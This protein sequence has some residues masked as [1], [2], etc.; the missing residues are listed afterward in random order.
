MTVIFYILITICIIAMI[1]LI[2]KIAINIKFDGETYY[3][4][5]ARN[6][7]NNIHGEIFDDDAKLAIQYGEAIDNPRAI[8]HY[9][10][11]TVYLINA[12]D[13]KNAH[14]HFTHA[15]NHVI[16]GKVDRKEANF[17]IDR[18][19]DYEDLFIDLLDMDNLPIQEAILAHIHDMKLTLDNVHKKKKKIKIDKN[20]PE[21]TQKILLSRQ[22]WQSDSQNVHDSAIY[23]ELKE[24][25]SQIILENSDIAGNNNRKYT[26]IKKWLYDNFHYDKEKYEMIKKTLNIIDN[27]YNI[28]GIPNIKEQDL[29]VNIWRRAYDPKNISV[30]ESIKNAI[31]DNLIDCVEGGYVVCMSGRTSKIWSSLARLDYNP[32][33]GI[34]KTKQILRN[35]IYEKSA[36]IVDTH[37]NNISDENKNIYNNGDTNKEIDDMINLIYSDIDNLKEDYEKLLPNKQLD[38]VLEECKSVI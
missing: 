1:F 26:D 31:A 13:T 9:R 34:F 25:L 36:K 2:Y 21:F 32:D 10:L 38:L 14:N 8:D 18:I 28:S 30:M 5:L 24:Q 35:E 37:L 23:K 12:N 33:M 27:N 11:G 3:Q 4:N 15:L 16:D 17:I 7:F 22:D 29:I 20:D 19:E 6:Y